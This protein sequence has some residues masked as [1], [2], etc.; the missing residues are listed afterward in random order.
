MVGG[1]LNWLNRHG[2]S[3]SES[4]E[5]FSFPPIDIRRKLWTDSLMD[6]FRQTG[7]GEGGGRR[8]EEVEGVRGDQTDE[9]QTDEKTTMSPCS[10]EK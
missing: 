7:R 6:A 2:M 8:G 9:K 1:E 5:T 3:G 10:L 4:A